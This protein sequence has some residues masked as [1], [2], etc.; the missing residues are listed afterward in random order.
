MATPWER[1]TDDD[2]YKT[3]LLL[4]MTVADFNAEA[5]LTR[6]QLGALF[7]AHQQQQQQSGQLR[8][9]SRILVFKCCFEYMYRMVSFEFGSSNRRVVLPAMWSSPTTCILVFEFWC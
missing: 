7:Q 3:W 8:C 6:K 4:D 9:C 5:P 1:M 2:A